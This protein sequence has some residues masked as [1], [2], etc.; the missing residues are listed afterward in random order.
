MSV[1]QMTPKRQGA[2]PLRCKRCTTALPREATFCGHCGE[3]VNKQGETTSSPSNTTIEERYQIYTDVRR[4][5]TGLTVEAAP[6]LQLSHAFDTL[7]NRAVIIRNLDVSSLPEEE[8]AK[9]IEAAQNEYDLLRKLQHPDIMP[10]IDLHFYERHIYTIATWPQSRRREEAMEQHTT[11]QDLLQSGIGLPDEEIALTWAYRICRALQQLHEQKI[12]IGNLDTQTLVMNKN[13][14]DGLP[15]LMVSW[16][17]EEIRTLLQSRNV[18]INLGSQH[19]S[20]PEVFRDEPEM[21]SDIYSVGAILYV[22]LTGSTPQIQQDVVARIRPPCDLASGISRGINEL[23]IQAL[24]NDPAERFQSAEEFADVLLGLC[25]STKTVNPF[26]FP[27]LQ[28]EQ[29]TVQQVVEAQPEQNPEGI[30]PEEMPS[31]PLPEM[32]EEAEAVTIKVTQLQMQQAHLYLSQLAAEAKAEEQKKHQAE[33]RPWPTPIPQLEEDQ[34]TSNA[35]QQMENLE[36]IDLQATMPFPGL[37]QE[38]EEQGRSASQLLNNFR[39]RI[40]GKLPAISGKLPAISSKLPALPA[41]FSERLAAAAQQIALR[42]GRQH[43]ETTWFKR[44][45]Y[46]IFGEQH[47]NIAAAAIIE[48]PL[49]IQPNQPYTLRIHLIGRDMAGHTENKNAGNGISGLVSGE[50]VHVEVRSALYQ[51]FAY[52][53]QQANVEIPHS[54]YAAEVTIPMQPLAE[55]PSGR[56]ERL[57]IQF[58]DE[59]H[60]PLYERPFVLEIYISH[61]VQSG[62]EGYNALTIPF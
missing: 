11:L 5:T 58:K 41:N 34:T 16:L 32:G 25:S 37:T 1:T 22:L 61:I 14:Y 46:F 43:Q 12:V 52:I 38:Q 53:V 21:R 42:P 9:A 48:A 24:C 54:G 56:R 18:Q 55:G 59:L 40:S 28:S 4:I 17:P 44:L 10:V 47:Y 62:Q 29:K 27:P 6:I 8:R 13:D 35:Q 23:V 45:Q 33:K 15:I 60:Q 19:F 57:H 20:A 51:H 36:A 39:Q 49:R 31:D 3:R 7:Q 50:K 2:E 30:Q 26:Q